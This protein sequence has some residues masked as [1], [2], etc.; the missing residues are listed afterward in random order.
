[1]TLQTA[2][3][4]VMAI[5]EWKHPAGKY[6]TTARA[7]GAA[8]HQLLLS[9]FTAGNRNALV[10]AKRTSFRIVEVSHPEDRLFGTNVPCC[11]IV[12]VDVIS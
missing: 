3:E 4:H 12:E 6:R 11:W 2:I 5:G 7:T 9:A 1:V 8:F 10:P